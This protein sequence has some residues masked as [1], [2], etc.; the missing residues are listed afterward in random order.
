[1]FDVAHALLVTWAIETLAKA[2]RHADHD[3]LYG[4]GLADSKYGELAGV[5]IRVPKLPALLPD[6]EALRIHGND[7]R[8][9]AL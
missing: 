2:R 3:R 8:A 1:M 5:K 9:R 6:V 7:S 4:L